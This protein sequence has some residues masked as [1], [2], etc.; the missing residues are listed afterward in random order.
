MARSRN[1]KPS[2]FK[3]EVLGEADPL[4]TILFQ[5]LWCLADRE[6]RLEDR[7]KRI[8]A[9]IFPYREIPSFNGYLTE[10]AR[11]GFIHRYTV[12]KVEYIHVINFLIHQ[13]PHKSEKASTIPKP[14]LKSDSCPITDK[15]PLNTG[16]LPV[17]ESLIPDSLNLIPDSLNKTNCTHTRTSDSEIPK[18]NPPTL[19]DV[20]GAVKLSGLD[21]DPE[22]FFH[23][24]QSTGWMINGNPMNNWQARLVVWAKDQAKRSQSAKP[25]R[26][27]NSAADF[28]ELSA[29]AAELDREFEK[30]A[31]K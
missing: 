13:S 16:T 28:D 12:D 20:C 19:D 25:G 4:L 14:P 21:V 9:E 23:H 22:L 10:L 30:N 31:S 1:I 7:P 8:K 5:G 2:L 26:R 17:K 24:F 27:E 3:N 29:Y 11:L 15:A 6:G 18:F